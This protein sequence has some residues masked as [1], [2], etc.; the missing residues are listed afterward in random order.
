MKYN[1]FGLP[2]RQ[3]GRKFARLFQGVH[4]V[5]VPDLDTP[6]VEGMDKTAARLRGVAASVKIARLPGEIKAKGGDDVRDVLAQQDGEQ[7]VRQAI[8]DAQP[9]EPVKRN[10]IGDDGR[11]VIEVSTAEH[12]TNDAA[13]D[14]LATDT[15]VFQRGGVLVHVVQDHN[16]NDGIIRA[17]IQP[18]IAQLPEA[19]LRERLTRKIR[20]VALDKDGLVDAHPPRW[21]IK[22]VEQRQQWPGIRY[23]AGVVTHPVLRPDGT[24]LS[25]P[26]YDT[27]TA[28]IYVPDGAFPPIVDR[29][30]QE[31]AR[32]AVDLLLDIVVDFPFE[33]EAHK[34]A[35]LAF[36]LTLLGR[37]AFYGPSPLFLMDANIRGSGKTFAPTGP[38]RNRSFVESHHETYGKIG[39]A[40]LMGGEDRLERPAA[41][42]FRGLCAASG[43]AGG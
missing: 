30:T 12:D 13:I 38:F 23:L 7:L 37:H 9:W 3:L 11:V 25:T 41:C 43:G 2:G 40:A 33:S 29:P 14:V 27:K 20:Y 8:A 22:A 34:A 35:W 39:I 6:S 28:L 10:E 15:E 26:G 16:P 1:A 36:L 21:H 31:Q 19:I 32:E 17:E 4:V 42:H 24:V 18:R 5:L